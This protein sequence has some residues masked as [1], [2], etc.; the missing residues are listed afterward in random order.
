MVTTG[1]VVMSKPG[2]TVGLLV[3]EEAALVERA[4]LITPAHTIRGMFMVSTLECLR[5]AKG[6]DAVRAAVAAAGFAGVEWSAMKKV[7]LA[8]FNKLRIEVSK[9]LAEDLGSVEA[10]VT[11][12]AAASVEIFFESVAGRTM[13][14][15]AGKDPHRLL[16][17][18]PNGYGLAVDDGAQRK[19]DKTGE[20]SG[21][22]R[23]TGDRL[24]P[25]H[26]L[27]VFSA[28]VSTVCGI[29]IDV[30]IT[31]PA[32]LDWTFDVTWA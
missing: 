12:I 6:E 30:R 23:F 29:Q 31:Q 18:A 25:C 15:L 26:Q 8:D 19:Y 22:F 24:G 4:A 7:P 9:R 20:K 1:E 10:G 3:P 11:R 14:L 2:W 28:A 13:M 17:A 21:V 27:G 16:G 32:L 5:R